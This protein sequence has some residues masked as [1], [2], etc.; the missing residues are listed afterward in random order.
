MLCWVVRKDAK[1]FNTNGSSRR[2]KAGEGSEG[3]ANRSK[4][5]ADGIRELGF[6]NT[7]AAK[8]VIT[9]WVDN[10]ATGAF[11]VVRNARETKASEERDTVGIGLET[12]G[13]VLTGHAMERDGHPG[14]E[15]RV[16]I[17]A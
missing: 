5:V 11:E 9:V 7:A 15:E 2:S 16:K 3:R 6:G 1:G 8:E 4:R 14:G 12:V 17:V 13:L 10:G